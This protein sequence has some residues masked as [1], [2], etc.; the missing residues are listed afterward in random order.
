MLIAEGYPS[1]TKTV[2]RRWLV[3]AAVSVL[4]AVVVYLL[5]VHTTT[6]QLLENAALRGADQAGTGDQNAADEALGE[7]TVYSLAVA[8]VA[9][10]AIGLAR[11]RVDLAI[12]AAGLIVAGQLITQAL[13]RFVL[14]RP[15]LVPVDGPYVE[16]S[17]PSGHTTIALTVLFAALLV[18]P[19]RWRG[20]AIFFVL[21]W[22]VGIGA[23]TVTAKWHRLSD[24]LAADAISLAVA[25]VASW[26]LAR[27]GMV[28][29]HDGPRRIPRVI[30]VVFTVLAGLSFLALGVV[31]SGAPLAQQGLEATVRDDA[32]VIY[33][34]AGSFASFGSIATALV[35]LAT[36]R[37]LEIA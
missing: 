36:W 17:L 1:L 22:A 16:N 37:R 5:A 13:K 9:V 25:C 14:P 15:S 6:G 35:F 23:Y 21:S 34:A 8:V 28:R 4:V 26:W 3:V 24:T 32:Y 33:L 10:A 27:R 19:Y 11:R 7:I 18:V 20:V 31:L 29:H 30:I 2:T 12:A